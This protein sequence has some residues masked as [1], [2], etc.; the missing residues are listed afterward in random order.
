M[1]VIGDVCKK[2]F[3]RVHKINS[4][5]K[6]SWTG[7]TKRLAKKTNC[8]EIMGMKAK[9]DILMRFKGKITLQKNCFALNGELSCVMTLSGAS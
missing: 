6:L 4:H 3:A 1:S 8:K 9:K 5:L 7:I 2:A